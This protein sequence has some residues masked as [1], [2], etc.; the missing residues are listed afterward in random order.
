MGSEIMN[1]VYLFGMD[2]YVDEMMDEVQ[3]VDLIYL[4]LFYYYLRN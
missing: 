3:G 4:C 2:I 1:T